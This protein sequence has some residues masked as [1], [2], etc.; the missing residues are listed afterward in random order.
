M[1]PAIEAIRL[2]SSQGPNKPTMHD[3]GGDGRAEFV[4]ALKI[5]DCIDIWYTACMAARNNLDLG[6]VYEHAGIIYFPDVPIDEEA[7]KELCR[8]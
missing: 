5:S 8:A 1:T 3:V 6:P 4:F 7:Y 2:F